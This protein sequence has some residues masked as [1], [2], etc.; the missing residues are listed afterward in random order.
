LRKGKHKTGGTGALVR[1]REKRLRGRSRKV[2]RTGER[3]EKNQYWKKGDIGSKEKTWVGQ[4]LQGAELLA[5]K[6][7][8]PTSRGKGEYGGVKKWKAGDGLES[9]RDGRI[10]SIE[11]GEGRCS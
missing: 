10:K 5:A 2:K 9:D 6:R 3:K 1:N 7:K 4:Y 8:S 11:K